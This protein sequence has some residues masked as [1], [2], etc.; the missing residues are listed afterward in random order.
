VSLAPLRR[1]SLRPLLIRTQ[2]RGCLV[3]VHRS[4][5][6]APYPTL[7]ENRRA[8]RRVGGEAVFAR[9]RAGG[10]GPSAV[11]RPAGDG[12][13]IRLRRADREALGTNK[14]VNFTPRWEEGRGWG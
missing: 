1:N 10:R 12:V 2:F 11:A 6:A 9:N 14:V 3:V 4:R 13:R 7:G 5:S 8:F